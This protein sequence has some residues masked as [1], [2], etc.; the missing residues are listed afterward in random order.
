MFVLLPYPYNSL[1]ASACGSSLFQTLFVSGLLAA[2]L[3][4]LFGVRSFP[5]FVQKGGAVSVT[6][7]RLVYEMVCVFL[8]PLN[9]TI[10]I[11]TYLQPDKNE[12]DSVSEP[13]TTAS[14]D[15]TKVQEKILSQDVAF[16]QEDLVRLFDKLP[17]AR[18][19]DL[20]GRSFHGR[21]LR[22]NRSVLDV[23][24]WLLVKPLTALGFGWGKRY[25][26]RHVGDPLMLSWNKRIYCP[27]PA[28]GNVGMVKRSPL[29]FLPL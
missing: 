17:K 4:F 16:V 15:S 22:T 19:V 10:W 28:W 9:W 13:S 24:H 7:P 26:S 8:W 25:C 6:F 23:P 21:I 18:A 27:L 12:W 1:L 29:G 2:A 5:W 3:F 11:S 14:F 20:I